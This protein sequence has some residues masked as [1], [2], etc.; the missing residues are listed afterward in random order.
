[1]VIECLID[2]ITDG[3]SKFEEKIDYYVNGIRFVYKLSLEK[4]VI[5]EKSVSISISI[6]DIFNFNVDLR[7]FVDSMYSIY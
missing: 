6:S 4:L 7:F 2:I 5:F 3:E 1:M